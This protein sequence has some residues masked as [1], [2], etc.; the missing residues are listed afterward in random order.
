MPDLS[1]RSLVTATAALPALA[2]P[3][4]AHATACTLPP[5][6]I[7]RFARDVRAFMAEL[8]SNDP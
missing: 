4:L 2:L 7:E 8:G 1:R 3:T 5:D 6:L